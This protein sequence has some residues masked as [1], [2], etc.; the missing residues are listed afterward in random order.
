MKEQSSF[1]EEETNDQSF[2]YYVNEGLY[3]QAP[4]KPL[5]QTSLKSNEQYYPSRI[6]GPTN[7][8]LDL[9]VGTVSCLRYV[10]VIGCSG[11]WLHQLLLLFTLLMD[12]EAHT[13]LHGDVMTNI[14]LGSEY[15][16]W[17]SKIPVHCLWLVL[18]IAGWTTTSPPVLTLLSIYTY[19]YFFF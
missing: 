6:W 16:K 18:R 15:V 9:T 4:I 7:D 10:W 3:K 14:N 12:L 5:P 2:M 17:R 1:E 8:G 13:L 19:H 11:K